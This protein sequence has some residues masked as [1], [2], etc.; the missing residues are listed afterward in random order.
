MISQ[1]KYQYTKTDPKDRINQGDILHGVNL[2]I[3]SGYSEDGQV[4]I[5]QLML[6]YAI[7]ITQECDLDHDY[8]NRKS[9]SPTQDK[10]LPSI[11]IV[12][13]YLIE[14]FKSG[15]HISGLIGNIWSSEQL[16]KMKQNKE[17]RFH[18]IKDSTTYQLPELMVDFKHVYAANRDVIYK[19][20]KQTYVASICE[21]FR[22]HLSIRYSNY[23]SRIGLPEFNSSPISASANPIA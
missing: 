11:L 5:K 18:Y 16:K 21:L 10:Y 3:H 6:D 22:E 19:N 1:I 9:S 2:I 12:P 14:N 15:N 20:I 17:D 23:L 8:N 13:A 7:V 4:E